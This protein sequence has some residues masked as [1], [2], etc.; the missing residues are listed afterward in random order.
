M[1]QTQFSLWLDRFL[2]SYYRH[3]PVNAT[4]IG[5][6]DYDHTPSQTCPPKAWNPAYPT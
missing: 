4:F 3:R 6:H 5:V 2:H 1:P